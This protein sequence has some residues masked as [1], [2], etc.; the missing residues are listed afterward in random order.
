M[1]TTTG[2]SFADRVPKRH[3]WNR[4]SAGLAWLFVASPLA[5][6]VSYAQEV[7]SEST[8]SGVGEEARH[9]HAVS[10][11]LGAATHTDRNETGAAIGLS[12]AFRI[13]PKWALGVKA[14]YASSTLERDWVL[15]ASVAFEAAER[16]EFLLGIGPEL[17]NRSEGEMQSVDEVEALLRLGVAYAFRVNQRMV[18]SPEFNADFGSSQVTFVYGLVLTLGL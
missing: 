3:R 15:L 14:E 4:V 2:S 5:A 8:K 18:L 6:P 16:L 7:E 9:R 17:A 10:L 13:A 11:F 1:P 12:Y